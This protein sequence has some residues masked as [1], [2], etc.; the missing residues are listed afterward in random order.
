MN[1]KLTPEQEQIIQ[2][3]LKSGQF[4]TPEEVVGRA[5]QVLREHERVLTR[6]GAIDKPSLAQDEAVTQMLAFVERNH[7][8]LDGIAVKDLI[9]EG[10]R[11]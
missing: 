11:L 9:H 2:D 5:L 1:L 6:Y 4:R 10:H 3:E 8:R 7:V